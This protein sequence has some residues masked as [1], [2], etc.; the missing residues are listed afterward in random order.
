[1]ATYVQNPDGSISKTLDSGQTF[2]V[3]PNDPRFGR[4]ANEAVG[5]GGNISGPI[6]APA[7]PVQQPSQ[8][9]LVPEAAINN[10]TGPVNT[11]TGQPINNSPTATPSQGQQPMGA[12][13][14]VNA[15]Q[16]QPA[17]QPAKQPVQQQAIQ[18][19]QQNTQPQNPNRVTLDGQVYAVDPATGYIYKNN[20]FVPA[21]NYQYIP[22]VVLDMARQA[23]A[24]PAQQQPAQQQ[25][26]Q[27]PAAP[28]QPAPLAQQPAAQP[29]TQVQDVLALIKQKIEQPIDITQDPSF[30][31]Y[32]DL[33]QQNIQKASRTIME[34][35]NS[36]GILNSTIT[37][38]Q[39]ATAEQEIMASIMPMIFQAAQTTRQNEL[40]NFFDLLG[41]YQSESKSQYS[42]Q[43]DSQQ[44]AI[45]ERKIQIEEEKLRLQEEKQAVEFAEKQMQAELDAEEKRVK[46]ALDRVKALG[47]VDNQSA[48][49]LGLPVGSKTLEA[50]KAYD[51]KQAELARISISARAA[52]TSAANAAISGDRLRM[53]QSKAEFSQLVQVWKGT[54][55]APTGL[56]GYGVQPGAEYYD[57]VAARQGDKTDAKASSERLYDA[58]SRVDAKIGK[59]GFT[60]QRALEWAKENKDNFSNSDYS[61]LLKHINDNVDN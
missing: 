26:V 58:I 8:T 33:A 25:P 40:K 35:L 41:A 51:S 9:D 6:S 4:V 56:E 5:A 18:P 53:E 61:K 14:T 60:K 10:F 11:D 22:Q 49:V 50:Q 47:Y 27:Q 19:P 15:S 13:P 32:M 23:K 3:A 44:A 48:V 21:E 54:G 29:Q 20:V 34:R 46:A 43:R 17:Q 45:D 1:M 7:K 36:R 37:R 12:I 2:N 38:D 24:Q 30:K 55:K 16:Q 28:Q 52:A 59:E 31:A 57:P 39:L 42:R